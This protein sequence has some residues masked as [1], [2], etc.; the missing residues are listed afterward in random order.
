MIYLPG[1]CFQTQ[2]NNQLRFF[3]RRA[4]H[5]STATEREVKHAA[6]LTQL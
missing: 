5:N 4:F 6:L 3:K 1:V 2:K